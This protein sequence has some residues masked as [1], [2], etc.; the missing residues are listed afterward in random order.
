MVPSSLLKKVILFEVISLSMPS[1]IPLIN[2]FIHLFVAMHIKKKKEE[3][4]KLLFHTSC[5]LSIS[6]IFLERKMHF[7][8]SLKQFMIN[9]PKI[10]S[11]GIIEFNYNCST[12]AN[13]FV[14]WR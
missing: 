4:I 2:E 13:G 11:H 1:P 12:S 8:Y 3:N 9:L 14:S 5:E 6:A 10:I 7:H